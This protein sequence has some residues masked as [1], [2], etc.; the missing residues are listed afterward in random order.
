MNRASKTTQ[1]DI[2]LLEELKEKEKS[3]GANIEMF[4]DIFTLTEL[5]TALKN[6]K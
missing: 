2:K 1:D 6:L 3:A 4:E 5:N